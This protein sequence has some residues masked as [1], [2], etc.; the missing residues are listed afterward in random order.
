MSYLKIYKLTYILFL[1]TDLIL[2]TGLVKWGF[3]EYRL[4]LIIVNVYHF[5]LMSTLR[6][7]EFFFALER[8]ISYYRIG[9]VLV[10]A[11]GVGMHVIKIS[12][13]GNAMWLPALKLLLLESRSLLLWYIY[14]TILFGLEVYNL[15]LL[16]KYKTHLQSNLKS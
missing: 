16:K 15:K 6:F 7:S 14:L 5:I 1:T 4:I 3:W 13:L 2:V 10:V 9:G 11:T 8:V 12:P